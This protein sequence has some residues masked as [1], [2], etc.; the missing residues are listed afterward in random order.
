[1]SNWKSRIFAYIIDMLI[2]TIILT[3]LSSLMPE[4]SNYKRLNDEL[5]TNV[6]MFID[7]KIDAQTYINKEAIICHDMDKENI[8]FNIIQS[9]V[10]IGY[11]IVLPMYYGGKTIG[12]KL[13]KLKIINYDGELS[14]NNLIIRAFFIN[15]LGQ[16][17]LSMAFI[18]ILPS[19]AYFIFTIILGLIDSILLVISTIRMIKREDHRTIHDLISGTKVIED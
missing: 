18:Y 15:G 9:L 7:G 4:N 17:L 1:M 11:F 12:K 6:Q 2:I 5:E 13:F 16:L 8:L 3:I 14:Y 10:V 19:M